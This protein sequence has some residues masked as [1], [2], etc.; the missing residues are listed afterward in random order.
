M[1]EAEAYTILGVGQG[2]S[3]PE[4]ETA[5]RLLTGQ[6]EA[7]PGLSSQDREKLFRLETAYRLLMN[8]EHLGRHSAIGIDRTMPSPI[9]RPRMLPPGNAGVETVP[10][11]RFHVL[12]LLAFLVLIVAAGAL[13][14][15]SYSAREAAG[16][17]AIPHESQLE[18]DPATS[19]S[20]A[21][22]AL[23]PNT[24]AEWSFEKNKEPISYR[25]GSLTVTVRGRPG[26]DDLVTPVLT[27]TAPGMAAHVVMGE[28]GSPSLIHYFGA[29]RLDRTARTDYLILRSFTGGAHCCTH[30]LAVGSQGNGFKTVDLGLW[31]GEGMEEFPHDISGDGIADFVLYDNAFLYAF[32][33]YAE[34]FAPPKILNIRGTD[35]TDVSADKAFRPLF[36]DEMVKAAQACKTP[37]PDTNPNGACA[38]YVAAAARVGQLDAAWEQMLLSYDKG[39]DWQLPQGCRRQSTDG[40]CKAGEEIIFETYPESLQYFLGDNGYIAR[41]FME[42][43]SLTGQPSF[44]CEKSQSAT[45]RLICATPELAAADRQMAIA[46]TKAMAFS[47]NRQAMRNEQRAFLGQRQNL[48]LAAQDILDLYLNRIRTLKSYTE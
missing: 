26:D 36:A 35:V 48:G 44:E 18:S 2:S 32:A 30:I 13:F 42:K 5:Y 38:S 3:R 22:I 1:D 20:K 9:T 8:P 16:I 45:L 6:F 10:D 39:S 25:V 33:S 14:W 28:S 34:S 31:D 47:P 29:G 17:R 4:V 12:Y 11:R 24:W 41:P 27:V 15:R 43:D 7:K 19:G 21:E 23:T 46:Y 40:S 37:E